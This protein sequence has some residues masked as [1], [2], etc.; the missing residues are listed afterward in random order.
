MSRKVAPKG[1]TGRT[2]NGSTRDVKV[3][4]IGRVTIYKRGRTYYLYHREKGKTVRQ[5]VEGNLNTARQ[6]ASGVI[7]RLLLENSPT[8]LVQA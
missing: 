7:R 6:Q 5:R 4:R 8:T 3:D 2:G 1:H